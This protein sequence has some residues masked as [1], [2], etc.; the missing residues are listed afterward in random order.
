M[1]WMGS[2][3]RV[4]GA[5]KRDDMNELNDGSATPSQKALIR[6]LDPKMPVAGLSK[7]SA[8]RIIHWLRSME[9]QYEQGEIR[10]EASQD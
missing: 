2:R 1:S 3:K 8:G 6:H 7:G 5:I 10:N 4:Q 9:G